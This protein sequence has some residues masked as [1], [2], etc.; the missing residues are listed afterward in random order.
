VEQPELLIDEV[1]IAGGMTV[2]EC[3]LWPS[4]PPPSCPASP[5]IRR[6]STHGDH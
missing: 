6:F 4:Q 3:D 1:A 5:E 2:D